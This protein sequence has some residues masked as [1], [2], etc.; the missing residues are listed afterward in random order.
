MTSTLLASFVRGLPHGVATADVTDRELLARF[1]AEREEQAFALLLRRHGPMVLGVCRR[2]LRDPHD[3]EDAFQATFLVLVKKARSLTEPDRVGPW[4]YGVACRTARKAQALAD[5]RRSR[6]QPIEDLEAGQISMVDADVLEWLDHELEALPQKYREPIVLCY[7]QGDSKRQAA[8]KL[9]CPEGTVSARLARARKLLRDRLI[10]RGVVFSA[11]ALSSVLSAET[12][13]AQVPAVLARTMTVSATAALN[14]SLASVATVPLS[15]Q[16]LAKGVMKMMW[17]SKLKAAAAGIIV[18]VAS[19]LLA[20][21]FAH[22]AL[23]SRPAVASVASIPQTPQSIDPFAERDFTWDM[24]TFVRMDKGEKKPLGPKVHGTLKSID[25]GKKTLVL[26]T[27]KVTDGKKKIEAKSFELAADAA[28][29]LHDILSKQEKLPEGKLEDLTP[30]T[31]LFLQLDVD[32]K[33]VVEVGARGPSMHC[34]LKSVNA[35]SNEIIVEGKGKTGPTEHM[36]TLHK[37]AKVILD[38]PLAKKGDQSQEAKLADLEENASIVVQLTVDGKR[39]LGVHVLGKTVLGRLVGYDAGNS[40]ITVSI[41]EE[42]GPVEKTFSVAK[43]ARLG[44]LTAGLPIHLVFST[45][46]KEKVVVA[47]TKKMDE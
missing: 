42:G 34:K 7:L 35:S 22:R 4:L 30:G 8:T 16:T 3:A 33:K 26:Q 38:N 45:T 2:A 36:F 6:L 19:G 43:D 17:L 10:R 15:V 28:I 37:D 31:H 32:E 27:A 24:P 41:K 13:R 44:D 12:L 1:L 29:F 47:Q 23:A 20:T 21:G 46:D 5:A 40:T 14:A 11:A 18:V 9:G 25:V 39:V